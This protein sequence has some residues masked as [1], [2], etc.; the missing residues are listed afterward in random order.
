MNTTVFQHELEKLAR[1]RVVKE[2]QKLVAAGRTDQARAMARKVDAAGGW[3]RSSG[4]LIKRLGSGAE[5]T[6]D[7]VVGAKESKGLSVRKTFDPKGPLNTK[8][9]REEKLNVGRRL[10]NKPENDQHFAR[11]NSKRMG[12]TRSGGRYLNYEHVEGSRPTTKGIQGGVNEAALRLDENRMS[13]RRLADIHIGNAITPKGKTVPKVV[14][15]IPIRDADRFMNVGD[16]AT[17]QRLER[18]GQRAMRKRGI[19][20]RLK[21]AAGRVMGAPDPLKDTSHP[22]IM[23]RRRAAFM[24]EQMGTR[25]GAGDFSSTGLKPVDTLRT[26]KSLG[27]GSRQ[28]RKVRGAK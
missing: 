4:K 15:Y 7:L 8:Q 12:K 22:Y 14:D 18:L 6:A 13:G 26:A 5:G 2:I 10:A 21:R 19:G 16:T 25:V 20:Q 11:L 24:N 9:V 27:P 23:K 1:S 3:T 17:A 28:P